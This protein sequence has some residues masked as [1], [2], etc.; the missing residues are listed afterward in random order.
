MW[1]ICNI[2]LFL[3]VVLPLPATTSCLPHVLG[4][5]LIWLMAQVLGAGA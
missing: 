3:K 5:L 1:I 2:I 4:T